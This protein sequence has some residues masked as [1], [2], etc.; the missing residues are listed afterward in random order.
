M[1]R[2][3]FIFVLG[4]PGFG[5]IPRYAAA[6]I[7]DDSMMGATIA[8]LDGRRGHPMTQLQRNVQRASLLLPLAALLHWIEE[9]PRFPAWEARHFP[10]VGSTFEQLAASHVPIFLVVCAVGYAGFRS[11]PSGF[12]IWAVVALHASFLL[13]VLFQIGCTVAFLEYVPGNVTCALVFVPFAAWHYTRILQSEYLR[14]R[15]FASAVMFGAVTSS[16]LSLWVLKNWRLVELPFLP[17]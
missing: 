2:P 16:V 17:G 5:A 12:G 10:H 11:R 8:A 13:N 14:P 9:L 6:A 4:S 1:V 15:G 7:L 3:I